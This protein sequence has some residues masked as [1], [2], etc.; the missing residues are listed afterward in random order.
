MGRGCQDIK[1]SIVGKYKDRIFSLYWF[2][3]MNLV[4]RIFFLF[5]APGIENARKAFPKM[6]ILSHEGLLV[7]G[8]E[9]GFKTA[10]GIGMVVFKMLLLLNMLGS[11]EQENMSGN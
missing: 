10:N 7:S 5:P 6:C 3:P 2:A 1:A 8:D 11:S 9:L 4:K